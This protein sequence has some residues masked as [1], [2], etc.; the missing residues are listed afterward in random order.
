MQAWQIT[1][2]FKLFFVLLISFMVVAG[3]LWFYIRVRGSISPGRWR[4]LVGLRMAGMAILL[5]LLFRPAVGFETAPVKESVPVVLVDVSR[6]MGV[7]DDGSGPGRLEGVKSL[8]RENLDILGQ[9]PAARIFVF[10]DKLVAVKTDQI[11]ALKPEGKTTDI[12]NTLSVLNLHVP[13]ENIQAVI[14]LTDGNHLGRDNPV[15]AVKALLRPVYCLGTGSP[16]TS[17]GTNQVN[18]EVADFPVKLAAQAENPIAAQVSWQGAGEGGEVLTLTAGV[19]TQKTTE[20]AIPITH[21]AGKRQVE[22]SIRPEAVGKTVCTFSLSR[23]PGK[24]LPVESAR[25]IHA[26]ALPE[27]LRLLMVEGQVRPEYK[28]LKQYLQSDP[29]VAVA[30]FVQ[31]RPGK[32]LI[33][34][35]IPDYHPTALPAGRSEFQKFDLVILGDISGRTFTNQQAQWT[36]EI[37]EKGSGLLF[38]AGENTGDLQGTVWSDL[39]PVQL[40]AKATW[41]D[42]A[43]IP[44]LTAAGKTDPAFKALEPFL[45]KEGHLRGFFSVGPAL[46]AATVLWEGPDGLPVLAVRPEGKGKS[47]ILTAESTWRWALNPDPAL[48]KKLYQTFWGELIRELA[49]RNLTAKLKPTLIVNVDTNSVQTGKP[50]TLRANLFDEAGKAVTAAAVSA[51]LLKNNRPI[52]SIKLT[53]DQDHFTGRVTAGEPGEYKIQ[54]RGNQL[55]DSIPLSVYTL[56]QELLQVRLNKKLLDDLA[57]VGET[58]KM[59]PPQTFGQILRDLRERFATRA[60]KETNLNEFRSFDHR[61]F[62]LALFIIA[63]SSEWIL[64]YRWRLR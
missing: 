49:N 3:S 59:R 29:A 64:R 14:L 60:E 47:A 51:E 5:I 36:K 12:Y 56:D 31:I 4:V 52:E 38:L 21:P 6:S 9:K 41:Q 35:Q 20:K 24:T 2:H 28:F 39:L 37:V 30:A 16:E 58:E 10:S 44:R 17:A 50:V 53:A 15:D 22:I 25:E 42:Q 54:V 46:P 32:F 33:N 8:L 45:E 62:L 13:V 23:R 18:L 48:R 19:D 43:F 34:N 40:K 61:V 11:E 27:K 63:I 7:R 1:F 55:Q 57:R 26:L